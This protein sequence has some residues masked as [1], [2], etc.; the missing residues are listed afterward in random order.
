M[1][2]AAMF[3]L[4]SVALAACGP[5]SSPEGRITIKL[6]ELKQQVDSLKAQNSAIKDSLGKITDEIKS[7]KKQ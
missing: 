2:I 4:L 6:N 5:S 3:I 7:L 1:K